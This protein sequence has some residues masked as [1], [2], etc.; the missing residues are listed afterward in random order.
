MQ[1]D[2]RAPS[3]RGRRGRGGGRTRAPGKK[4]AELAAE[5]H[6]KYVMD[7]TPRLSPEQRPVLV[8]LDPDTVTTQIGG[9]VRRLGEMTLGCD[10][11]VPFESDEP[12]EPS[13]D[14]VDQCFLETLNLKS[15]RYADARTAI[16]IAS[17]TGGGRIESIRSFAVHRG[18]APFAKYSPEILLAMPDCAKMTVRGTLSASAGYRSVEFAIAFDEAMRKMIP[19]EQPSKLRDQKFYSRY[20]EM[21]LFA[22]YGDAVTGRVL[23]A[24]LGTSPAPA[25]EIDEEY[26]NQ[27]QEQT[28]GSSARLEMVMPE[29]ELSA[30]VAALA[31]PSRPPPQRW[32]WVLVTDPKLLCTEDDDLLIKTLL[33]SV[34]K[35]DPAAMAVDWQNFATIGYPP[36]AITRDSLS[37]RSEGIV[38]D[39]IANGCIDAEDCDAWIATRGD[40]G[41]TALTQAFLDGGA[42]DAATA[43][44]SLVKLR[45]LNRDWPGSR[46]GGE[47]DD[48]DALE[49]LRRLRT[50]QIRNYHAVVDLTHFTFVSAARH[51]I[52]KTMS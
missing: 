22:R 24:E 37:M 42:G 19:A 13:R 48:I 1:V 49:A 6:A 40:R 38:R 26:E 7:I 45:L 2:E 31:S 21:R 20:A 17:S 10:G 9:I 11:Y 30:F 18:G 52:K 34:P 3:A 36:A 47:D 5:A 43:F 44:A 25:T 41:L 29:L 23:C 8:A 51:A 27:A 32:Y 35:A 46:T 4:S 14:K 33:A 16:I 50:S 39:M 12:L 28:L 15:W